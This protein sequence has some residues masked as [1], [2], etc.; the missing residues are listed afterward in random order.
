M[1]RAPSSF[2]V[3]GV[4]ASAGGL[5]A[6]RRLLGALTADAPLALVL[7]QH[8][9]PSLEGRVVEILASDSPL[10]V[11]MAEDGMEIESGHAYVVPERH[12]ATVAKDRVQ[13]RP[14]DGDG[15]TLI[16]SFLTSVAAGAGVRACGVLLSGDG[17]DGVQGLREIRDAG[18]ATFVQDPSTAEHDGTPRAAIASQVPDFVGV[19]EE[20]AVALLRLVSDLHTGESTHPGDCL[21][22]HEQAV[23]DA[24]R[25]SMKLSAA[26]NK[27]NEILM[28][29]L[30]LAG[31]LARLV[32]EVSEAAGA[33]KCLVIDVHRNE[34]TVSHVRNVRRDLVGQPRD[35]TF[36]PA[37][38]LA[39]AERRPV[40]IGD[41]WNDPRTN[42]D[43]VVGYDLRAFQLIP[44]IVDGEVIGVLAFAYDA[45]RTFDADDRE[46]ADRMATA[47]SLAL[48]NAR[49]YEEQRALARSSSVLAEASALLAAATDV[50]EVLPSVLEMAAE[51]LGSCGAH[52]TVREGGGWRVRHRYGPASAE[53]GQ[54]FSD[55]EAPSAMRVLETRQPH[56]VLDVLEAQNVNLETAR[57]LGYRSALVYPLVQRDSVVGLISFLFEEP[58]QGFSAGDLVFASRLAYMISTAEENSRLLADPAGRTRANDGPEGS[59]LDRCEH[60]GT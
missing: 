33:D 17:S 51:A 6:F 53:V 32:G 54:V 41:T 34:Y 56:I 21:P 52:E 38:A 20:I 13:L 8:P 49:L 31:V 48:K 10:P 47:M 22:A 26:L 15:R 46:F 39:A 59:R 28:S 5:D 27:I 4:G 19:P 42:K 2:A 3:V 35:A 36:Y 1:T 50:D 40:L 25:H 14:A 9:D 45:P 30:T 44:L 29:E 55:A 58:K 37:F 7:V 43:F 12:A 24:A 11:H 23:L 60:A 57:R 16:D 18:G